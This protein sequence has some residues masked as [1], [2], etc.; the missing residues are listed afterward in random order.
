MKLIYFFFSK[1]KINIFCAKKKKE[2]K[3]IFNK[4]RLVYIIY[5]VRKTSYKLSLCLF[6]ILFMRGQNYFIDSRVSYRFASARNFWV[7]VRN[8]QINLQRLNSL[9]EFDEE[10]FFRYTDNTPPSYARY[11]RESLAAACSL[12]EHLNVYE[13]VLAQ[14]IP[15]SRGGEMIFDSHNQI[16]LVI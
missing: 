12:K 1:T 10:P 14:F 3:F 7:L 13:P 9:Y 6:T 8:L 15:W 4:V 11:R 16:Y 2:V 5:N